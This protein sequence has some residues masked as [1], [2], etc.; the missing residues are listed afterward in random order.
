[1]KEQQRKI[2]C[3]DPVT[4]LPGIKSVTPTEFHIS[5]RRETSVVTRRKGLSK[6]D[7]V[8]FRSNS[9]LMDFPLT[10]CTRMSK[11]R[12]SYSVNRHSN[13]YYH[14]V[15]KL[16]SPIHQYLPERLD[17]GCQKIK[18]ILFP[19]ISIPSHNK[20][21]SGFNR[22]EY[23]TIYS[24]TKKHNPF[25]PTLLTPQDIHKNVWATGT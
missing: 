12:Q 18:K 7:E 8:I 1:M 10:V 16:M 13:L 3:I 5:C 20:N 21:Q 11:C 23:K 14:T 19:K 4:N 24:K 17:V 22:K 25:T 15:A 2:S 9:G 6:R